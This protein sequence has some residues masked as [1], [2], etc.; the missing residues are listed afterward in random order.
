MKTPCSD[1]LELYLEKEKALGEGSI[2]L[3]KSYAPY[4]AARNRAAYGQLSEESRAK[5]IQA[6]E[7]FLHFSYPPLYATDYMKL[8]RNGNR[9]DFEDIYF[10]RRRALN[11]LVMAECAEGQGRFLDD[12]VN[13]IYAL[14][15]ESGWQL[16][17]HNSYIRDTP[18]IILPDTK[19]P[20]VDLFAAETGAQLAVIVYL[21]REALD[22]ISPLIVKRIMDELEQRII[23]PYLTERF[24][25][26]GLDGG[27]MN[28]W[29]P[30]CTQNVLLTAFFGDFSQDT[31]TAVLKRAC[32][33][34]DAFLDAY[35]EDGCCDEGAQYYHHAGGCLFQALDI[36]DR[37][38]GGAFESLFSLNKI[39]NIAAYI[40]NV[41]IDDKYYFN[42]ADCS[43]VAGRAGAGEY[44]FGKRTGQEDLMRFSAKDYVA[45]GCSLYPDEGVNLY[46]RL[47]TL[48]TG[49][50]M[51]A[52]EADSS[53]KARE[54][55]LK[56]CCADTVSSV[57]ENT[58]PSENGK[59]AFYESTG[60]FIA[61][62]TNF[63]LAAKAG[64]NADSHNHN[65][66][67]SFILY[68]NG[69]PLFADIGV[70]TYSQKTFSD[71]RYE[72]WTMQSGYHNLPVINNTEQK[73]GSEYCASQVKASFTEAE[74]CFSMEIAGAYPLQGQENPAD[75]I[76]YLRRLSLDREH[77]R[78]LLTDSTNAENVELHFITYEK[79][80]LF[81]DEIL[82]EG[83]S[84]VNYRG[85]APVK[86]ETLPITDARLQTAWDHDLYRI[87][88][89]MT[90]TE[91]SMEIL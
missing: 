28:N 63:A 66:V 4:P 10:A 68:K 39:K 91:F 52:Y 62:G 36:I 7:P 35:G 22:E 25:W 59:Q 16:P 49:E 54:Y 3:L 72:I 31:R 69:K 42:F 33:S 67:G 34:L 23:L 17:A 48:F 43:P 84:R 78:V 1:L 51:K 45:G 55:S 26:I 44:L 71:R 57:Q 19:R 75:K 14:C 24:W 90:E 87:I 38:T 56:Y 8:K 73:D 60:L 20:V 18:Q 15:E 79:P 85:A 82:F 27:M 70:E 64:N 76:F 77:N 83:F 89:K 40:L 80:V 65:D 13:G 37:V 11:T 47:Q 6:G 74:S 41:H 61:C 88:L 58:A 86:V 2:R 30:W 9:S 12:I 21:L 81:R 29:T 46:Y 53:A 50:E 5:V 32:K